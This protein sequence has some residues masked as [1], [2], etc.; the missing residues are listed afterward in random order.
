VQRS[1]EPSCSASIA[2]VRDW[3][4]RSPTC[5]PAP[6]VI[7]FAPDESRQGLLFNLEV[8]MGVLPKVCANGSFNK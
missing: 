8:L 3:H 5:P 7:V 1:V 2:G 4:A 6:Q